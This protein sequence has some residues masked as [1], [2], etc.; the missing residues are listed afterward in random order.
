[1]ASFERDNAVITKAPTRESDSSGV[2]T[3]APTDAD[4]S[5]HATPPTKIGFGFSDDSDDI[6]TVN[7]GAKIG[8]G[9]S[10]DSD[11]ITTVNAGA[12]QHDS[13]MTMSDDAWEALAMKELEEEPNPMP[14]L[15]EFDNFC[16]NFWG[17]PL[18]NPGPFIK[19]LSSYI[20]IQAKTEVVVTY[21]E[22]FLTL[23]LRACLRVWREFL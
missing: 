11:G 14:G 23:C 2:I 15:A 9:F 12:S 3:S 10:D 7:A 19:C 16:M 1:M 18:I 20:T 5:Q 8:S 13:L 6:T 17:P 21:S 22:I 4:A